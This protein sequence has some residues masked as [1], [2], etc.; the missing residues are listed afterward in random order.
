VGKDGAAQSRTYQSN[1]K[2]KVKKK[3][4]Q[5][6]NVYFFYFIN[7]KDVL[8]LKI[9]FKYYSYQTSSWFSKTENSFQKQQIKDANLFKY[10]QILILFK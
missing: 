4:K 1:K 9:V 6:R 5:F 7:W 2:L 8:L 10:K 3:S